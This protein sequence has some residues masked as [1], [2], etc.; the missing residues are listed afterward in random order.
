MHRLMFVL[1]SRFWPPQAAPQ[2]KPGSPARAAGRLASR[3]A[4]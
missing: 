2:T 4:D 3:R 1:F